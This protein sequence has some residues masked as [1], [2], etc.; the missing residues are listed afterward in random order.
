MRQV[1]LSLKSVT[2]HWVQEL[3]R[4]CG[5]VLRALKVKSSHSFLT[6]H[7]RGGYPSGSSNSFLGNFFS[8]AVATSF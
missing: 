6:S 5:V 2:S 4:H 7:P 8:Q 1:Y 3:P